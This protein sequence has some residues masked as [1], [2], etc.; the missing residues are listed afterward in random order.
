[1]SAVDE[2]TAAEITAPGT[3]NAIG[4]VTYTRPNHRMDEAKASTRA[5]NAT[6]D[7]ESPTA[8]NFGA[9]DECVRRGITEAGL[10]RRSG[11]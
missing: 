10:T 4:A 2:R 8:I 3:A 7:I 9:S 6:V 1:M 5:A 11:G